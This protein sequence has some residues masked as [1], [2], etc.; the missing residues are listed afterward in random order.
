MSGDQRVG[1]PVPQILET[2]L[3]GEISLYDPE[4]ENVTILNDTA[5][6]VWLLCDGEH[7]AEEIVNLLASSYGVN[8]DQIRDEVTRT[9]DEFIETG[10]LPA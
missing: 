6:D 3:D 4:N 5:S 7:S 1:P 2:E 8:A 10:L 9:I